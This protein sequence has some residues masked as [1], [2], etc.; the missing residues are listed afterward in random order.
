MPKKHTQTKSTLNNADMKKIGQV[1]ADTIWDAVPQIVSSIIKPEIERLEEK[2]E[3]LPT[4]D[5]FYTENDKL[6]GMLKREEEQQDLLNLHDQEQSDR[7]EAL[8]KL[9]HPGNLHFS[10]R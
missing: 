5:E 8:E 4:K 10:V 7:L 1:V 9:H 6:A 2:I 3:H